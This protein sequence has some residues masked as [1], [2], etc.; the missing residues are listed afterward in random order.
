MRDFIS[1]T[2]VTL[3]DRTPDGSSVPANVHAVRAYRRCQARRGR[4]S[5]RAAADIRARWPFLAKTAC[6]VMIVLALFVSPAS[7]G[8]AKS[9]LNMKRGNA[10]AV[11]PFATIIAEASQ[12]FGISAHWIRAVM[13][14]ESAGRPHTVSP[15]GAMGLMQ[16]MPKT[17]T[18]LRTRY[19][20]GNDPYDARN[21]VLAGAAYLRELHDRYGA[22]G[23]L[24]AYNAGPG[25]YDRHLA[26]GRPLPAETREYV[27][28]LAPMIEGNGVGDQRMVARGAPTW[29]QASLFVVR[30]ERNS[31]GNR[32]SPAVHPDRPS[33]IR[34]VVDLSAL[35]PQSI[36]LFVHRAREARPQ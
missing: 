29:R 6:F 3:F 22:P 13:R 20:L 11:D 32:L 12:R 33:N 36:G 9:V 2:A 5:P 15:K 19:G 16:I 21:N 27:A 1:R 18:E 28:K 7:A 4:T 23:F 26:T 25:R 34:L 17:W 24:A 35:A 31:P 8:H 10:P 14:V 30:A